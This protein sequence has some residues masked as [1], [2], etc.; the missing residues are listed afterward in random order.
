MASVVDSY[1]G[2]WGAY[3]ERIFDMWGMYITKTRDELAAKVSEG[4]AIMNNKFSHSYLTYNARIDESFIG[5]FSLNYN[6]SLPDTHH[7]QYLKDITLTGS[8]SSNVV[9]NT[10]DNNITGNVAETT[11]IF[12]GASSEYQ[13]S[14]ENGQVTVLDLQDNR[15]DWNTV[16]SIKKLKFSDTTIGAPSP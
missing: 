2:L 1:Y 5:D 13:I 10:L 9:V 4:A 6:A 7:S 3:K 16:T 12:S 8:N 11:V 15:D 14:N